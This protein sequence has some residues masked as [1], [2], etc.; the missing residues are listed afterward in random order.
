MATPTRKL[1]ANRIKGLRIKTGLTQEKFA[2]KIGIKYKYYQEYESKKPRDIRLSTLEKIAK[3][4]HISL[5]K[6][7]KL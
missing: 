4:L 1:L 5:S 2:E 7:F 6:L 3:G